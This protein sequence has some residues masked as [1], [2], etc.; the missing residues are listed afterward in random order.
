MIER[1]CDQQIAPTIDRHTK[2]LAQAPSTH[3]ADITGTGSEVGLSDHSIGWLIVRPHLLEEQHAT[4]QTIRN[5]Q[6]TRSIYSDS[7]RLAE[8]PCVDVAYDAA[9]SCC[10]MTHEVWLAKD[11]V[12]RLAI[13]AYVSEPKHSAVQFISYIERTPPVKCCT[14]W[15]A[16][17]PGGSFTRC[18]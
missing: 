12:G 14:R 5:E 17:D 6:S 11:Q 2:R 18:A 8:I 7:S 1:I 4:V 13:R 3:A 10:A 9:A 16:E 15:L